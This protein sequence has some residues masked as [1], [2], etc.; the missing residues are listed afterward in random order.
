HDNAYDLQVA[1]DSQA[2][3]PGFIL[4]FFT[5]AGHTVL[6]SND[7]CTDETALEVGMDHTC[8]L[9]RG[10]A[11]LDCPGAH[12]LRPDRKKGLQ[13]K[14]FVTSMNHPVKARLGQT[15]ILQESLLFPAIQLGQFTF[16][17]RA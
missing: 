8:G 4:A 13:A 16:E 12:F 2:L 10:G 7:Y 9:R 3:P 14:Q 15:Q 17:R 6:V 11:S 5:T 1:L